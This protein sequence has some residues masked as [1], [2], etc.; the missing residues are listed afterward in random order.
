MR[1]ADGVQI[2]QILASAFKSVYLSF[3]IGFDTA[4]KD[5]SKNC[6]TYV[7]ITQKDLL[8][9]RMTVESLGGNVL[10]KGELDFECGNVFSEINKQAL[11]R[12]SSSKVHLSC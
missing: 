6:F 10:L 2:F 12:S 7:D 9:M 5:A 4:K 11:T 3:A 1:S 8:P